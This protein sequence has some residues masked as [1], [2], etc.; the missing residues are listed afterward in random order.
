MEV[1]IVDNVS[2][3]MASLLSETIEHSNDVRIAVAFV[4]QPGLKLIWDP[5]MTILQAGAYLEFLVG[6]D[7]ET[8]EH[9]ALQN[10]FE[11][12]RNYGNVSLWCY[13]KANPTGIYH[14]KLYLMKAGDEV[15]SIVG[16]SN[17]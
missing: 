2:R 3:D 13:S 11:L 12:R 7:L 16:S 6:L 1:K 15:T 4:S 9:D 14:P 8:T 5:M 17:L 10:L